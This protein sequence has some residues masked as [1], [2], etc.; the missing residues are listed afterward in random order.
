MLR[1]PTGAISI[2]FYY[3]YYFFKRWPSKGKHLFD[4]LLWSIFQSSKHKN[5]ICELRDQMPS[6]WTTMILVQSSTA[7]GDV[8]TTPWSSAMSIH[9][10]YGV[11]FFRQPLPGFELG[12]SRTPILL[13]VYDDKLDRSAVGPVL[14]WCIL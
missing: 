2:I 14:W 4:H 9:I 10:K 7:C 12:T 6:A 5:S 3:Y 8:P 11:C 13:H 1:C